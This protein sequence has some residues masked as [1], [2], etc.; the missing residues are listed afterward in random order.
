MI[1]Y[2]MLINYDIL[3]NQILII[4]INND[5]FNMHDDH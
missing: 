1:I 4:I 5:N 3:S 2:I